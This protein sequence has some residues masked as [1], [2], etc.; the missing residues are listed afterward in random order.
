MAWVYCSN[1]VWREIA[2]PGDRKSVLYFKTYTAI[3]IS[4]KKRDYILI[5]IL[6]L[7]ALIA[8]YFITYG[9]YCGW[10]GCTSWGGFPLEIL[11]RSGTGHGSNL[12]ILGLLGNSVLY[13]AIVWVIVR[14]WKKFNSS[15]K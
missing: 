15:Q 14:L 12:N 9:E 6:T 13:F 8:S 2:Q 10:E 3:L 4:M 5:S 11:E 7:V 1:S